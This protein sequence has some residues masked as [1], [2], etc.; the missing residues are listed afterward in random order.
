M[1]LMSLFTHWL[2]VK[3][4][5]ISD[6]SDME[7]GLSMKNVQISQDLFCDLILY[8]LYNNPSAEEAIRRGLSRK[9]D[10]ML[11]HERF[12]QYKTAATEAEREQARQRYLESIGMPADFRW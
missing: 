10:A 7:G 12:T 3:N 6:M 4:S 11:C 1:S 5:D 9:L 2:I 8:H